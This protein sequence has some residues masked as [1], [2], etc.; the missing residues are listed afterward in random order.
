[1]SETD[2]KTEITEFRNE[3]GKFVIGNSYGG[4][5]KGALNGL[6]KKNRLLIQGVIDTVFTEA[7]VIDCL[8]SMDAEKQLKFLIDALPYVTSKAG[9]IDDLTNND[10][11]KGIQLTIVKRES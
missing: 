4:K 6:T 1:M 9:S 2:K 7:H 11:I 8:Y 5:T 3:Q 10:E